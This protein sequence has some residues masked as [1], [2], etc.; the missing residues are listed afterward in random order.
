MQIHIYTYSDKKI[1][2]RGNG[3]IH[4]LSQGSHRAYAKTVQNSNVG[5]GMYRRRHLKRLCSIK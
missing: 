4:P 2:K 1:I 5:I 3:C